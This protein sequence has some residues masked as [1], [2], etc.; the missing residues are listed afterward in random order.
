MACNK[1]SPTRVYAHWVDF[2]NGPGAGYPVLSECNTSSDTTTMLLTPTP[3]FRPARFAIFIDQL[4]YRTQFSANPSSALCAGIE[5]ET[6]W[7]HVRIKP[8]RFPK[9][10]YPGSC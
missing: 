9:L 4:L 8:C 6:Y 5:I 10:A 1:R 7:F 3:E 2:I